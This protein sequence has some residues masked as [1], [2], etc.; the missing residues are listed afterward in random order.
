MWPTLQG[1]LYVNLLANPSHLEAVNPVVLGFSRAK[2]DIE[3][4]SDY[5]KVL[6]IIIHG[7]AAVAGQGIGQEVI[8]MSQ[9]KGY[10]N[11]GTIHFVINNQ[12]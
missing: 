4:Q 9:L 6:P 8:Q 1:D 11:F 3:Y 5:S 2:A 7:D 10:L 12:I